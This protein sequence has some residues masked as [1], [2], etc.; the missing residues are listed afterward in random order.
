MISGR[1]VVAGIV[2][3]PVA[4]SL[5]PLIHNAW[6]AAAGIDG[7]YV[8]FAPDALGFERLAGGFRGG[9]IRGLN[10][11]VPFKEAALAL[12]D[13]ASEAARLAGAANVLLFEPDGRIL[14]DNTDGVGL[15]RA[16][17][18]QAPAWDAQLGPVTVLGAGGA[19]RGAVAALL[20]AGAPKV[21]V[22]NRTPE[23]AE[24]L[25]KAMGPRA[26]ALPLLHAAGALSASTAVINAT[27]A[28]LGGGEGPD[29]PLETTPAACVVMDMVY[30]PLMTP[31][32]QRAEDLGR[33]IVDGLEML[34]RQAEPSFEA[35][36]GEYPPAGVDV[37]RLALE[38][39]A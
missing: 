23:K 8:P 13:T 36:F 26:V 30:K 29:V 12:A 28:G 33:P 25:A 3:R 21:W 4:H 6:L 18:A 10:V 38:Q 37:R 11:T 32:L 35:F 14:A 7:V 20:L 19:A 15:L 17:A 22:V 16:F 1:T 31:F 2:G 34:I 9:A 5:S 39:I 27:S 24:A